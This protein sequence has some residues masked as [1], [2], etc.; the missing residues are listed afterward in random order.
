[1]QMLD[2][3][4]K[5]KKHDFFRALNYLSEFD[6]EQLQQ[7]E[8][9]NIDDYL[10]KVY[11]KILQIKCYAGI[12]K[13]HLRNFLNNLNAPSFTIEKYEGYYMLLFEEENEFIDFI[14]LSKL[15]DHF[16]FS[17]IE[18]VICNKYRKKFFLGVKLYHHN[19]IL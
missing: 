7:Q 4:N 13:S 9:E 1:M 8:I 11:N 5:P 3:A 19:I 16:K 2:M 10:N 15:K 18:I 17:K 14:L 6:I 12:K